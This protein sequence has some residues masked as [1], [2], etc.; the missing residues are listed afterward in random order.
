M[1]LHS[2]A[3]YLDGLVVQSGV[4]YQGLHIFPVCITSAEFEKSGEELIPLS[5]GLR[6]GRLLVGETGEMDKVRVRSLCP[7][8]AVV[9]D[10]E[11]LIGGAQ[12]RM[13]NASALIAR[14]QEAELPS[15]CIEVHR[16]DIK[17]KD[18][19]PDDKRAFKESD[20]AYGALRRLR[21]SQAEHSLRTDRVVR[22]DQKAVWENI[23]KQFGISGARTK[24]LDMHDLYE[25]WDA[26]L[27]VYEQRFYIR[28]NQV[29]MITFLDGRAWF[30]DIF[31]NHDMLYKYFKSLVKGY[32]F[33]ALIRLE[34]GMPPRG[35]PD[36]DRA[37]DILKSLR[38]AMC[39]P[40]DTAGSPGLFFSTRKGFGTAVHDGT[41]L[42]HL[43]A[44]SR[45]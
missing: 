26:A 4:A 37:R 5:Q 30:A 44:C 33:D 15:S 12:N 23:V 19:I 18:E 17:N 31:L 14:G 7:H 40:F 39:H 25:F 20:M 32:A 21:M 43:T 8:R 16:W 22:L 41:S 10:G 9:L 42:I 1:N 2:I 6:S 28:K 45:D 38:T 35:K 29:G 36:L 27:R 11:T 24:T 13:I 34:A 3:Q